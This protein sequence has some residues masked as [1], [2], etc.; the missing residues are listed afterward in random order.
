MAA[1]RWTED[2]TRQALFL[3]FQMPFGRLHQRAP[4]IIALAAN[5]NRTPSSI[6]MKLSNFAS[7]DPEIIR[8]GRKGLV[9]ASAL[10][11]A[12]FSRFYGKWDTLVGEAL[13]ELDVVD[14]PPA[15]GRLKEEGTRFVGFAGSS[16]TQRTV[17]ARRGQ[18]F[19]RQAVLANFEE[20]CCITGIA[21][22]RLLNA[23]HIK[24]WQADIDHRHDPANGFAL[25]ATFDRAFDRGL[26]TI[27]AD[28]TVRVSR[29]L[30]EHPSERTRAHFIP[31]HR[32]R[33]RQPTRF[34]PDPDLLAWHNDI[35]RERELGPMRGNLH[36]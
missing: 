36:D 35:F 15:F 12:V 23:S 16:E 14:L 26:L 29:A 18:D 19:F 6:A 28:L 34:L 24:P 17:M 10:D 1:D 11:R 20:Q 27:E 4:E 9:G 31:H 22:V 7:L 5:L 3:Y 32:Q 30:L 33:I 21:D 25:S 13:S 8:S 2:Q